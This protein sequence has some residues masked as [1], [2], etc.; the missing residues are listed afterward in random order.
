MTSQMVSLDNL[1]GLVSF[2]PAFSGFGVSTFQK[3]KQLG[4]C[5]D[6]RKCKSLIQEWAGG[7]FLGFR[8]KKLGGGF[9]GFWGQQLKNI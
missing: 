6:L 8:C 1:V 7:I 4:K 3:L 9:W 2:F 5:H